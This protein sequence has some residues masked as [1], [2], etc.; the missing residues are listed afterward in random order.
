MPDFLYEQKTSGFVVG[1]DEAGCGPWAGPVVAAAVVF[2]TYD[3][4]SDFL[5]LINDSKQ[6]TKIKRDTAFQKLHE[7]RGILCD[8]G[9]GLSEVAEIDT[10]NI[11]Q[12]GLLAMTRAF[13]QLTVTPLAALVDGIAK[14]ALPLPI[15]LI[16]K[17]DSKSFSIAAASILAKVTRDEKMSAL[18]KDFPQY[19]WERNA[20][21]GTKEHQQALT[22]HG[23]TPHHRRS[24]APIA[25]LLKAA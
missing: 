14:P 22:L 24:F 9:I 20:G 3:L 11:R 1:L 23:V 25:E 12:A 16:K 5:N 19:G 6:L 2:L 7:V 15:Q 18:A 17:G 8:F 4:P 13:E 21:Y 10:F